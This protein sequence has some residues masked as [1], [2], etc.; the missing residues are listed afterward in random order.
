MAIF[1][2]SRERCFVG[3]ARSSGLVVA[4]KNRRSTK[5]ERTRP[6]STWPASALQD[7][8]QPKRTRHA[9][10]PDGCWMSPFSIMPRRGSAARS[11]PLPVKSR[12]ASP[13][14]EPAFGTVQVWDSAGGRVDRG[15]PRIDPWQ[16]NPD[17][18][19]A[20]A[21]ASGYLQGRFAVRSVHTAEGSFSFHVGAA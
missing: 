2:R 12:W 14:L 10:P 6:N 20:Q 8:P 5:Q 4:G 11:R 19:P 1:Q 7:E 18:P 21:I 9:S 17:A 3:D 15:K 13:N 16:S